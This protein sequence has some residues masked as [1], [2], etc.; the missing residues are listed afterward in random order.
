MNSLSEHAL[1]FQLRMCEDFIK[2]AIL[3]RKY[4]ITIIHGKGEGKLR[5]LVHSLL[6]SFP[7]AKMKFLTN[8]EGATEVLLSY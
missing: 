1:D 4:K 3:H 8:Q 2:N 6:N 5:D 7:E